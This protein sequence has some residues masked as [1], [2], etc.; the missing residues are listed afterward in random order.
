M[1]SQSPKQTSLLIGAS[2][3][4]A[5]AVADLL[6]EREALIAVS[7]SAAH[8]AHPN[9]RW[10]QC[11]YAEPEIAA[12]CQQ[13]NDANLNEKLK[14]I[15]IFNGS[16]HDEG[17]RPERSLN[18]YDPAAQIALF[19]RNTITP[20]L[21]LKYLRPL[22]RHNTGCTIAVL[23]ARIGSISDNQLGGW[24]SYRAS[25]AALNMLLKSAA[26]ELGR[27]AKQTRLIAFHPGTCDTPLSKPFQSNVPAEKLFSPKF[28]AER[29]LE[30]MA[31]SNHPVG[32]LRYVDWAGKE[33]E[34]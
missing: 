11:D 27:S 28:V 22:L 5:Q 26:I 8:I 24:Y 34:W 15:I 2:S 12:I 13:L 29:L 19:E 21:W 23:S 18:D 6:L 31:Q 3:A 7:R 33:I 20:L 17:I 14:R 10:L 32:T 25:K 16:L 1:T 9:L 30:V 4:I